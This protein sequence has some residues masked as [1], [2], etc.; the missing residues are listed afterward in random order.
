MLA[1][2]AMMTLSACDR[3]QEYIEGLN[4]APQITLHTGFES[5]VQIEDSIKVSSK[6]TLFWFS[7]GIKIEDINSNIKMV[8]M[9]TVQSGPLLLVQSDSI[10]VDLQL[11]DPDSKQDS[12][13]MKVAILAPGT[14]TV[15]F[16]II[17]SFSRRDSATLELQAFENLLPVVEYRVKPSPL[18]DHIRIIDLS[19]SYDR[20]SR[21]GGGIVLYNFH[22]DGKELTSTES[23]L[24]Y[25][26]PTRGTYIA[27]VFVTDNNLENS[28]EKSFSITIA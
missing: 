9:D 19:D 4:T 27:V 17:D 7:V 1:T 20:D 18:S 15:K 5:G 12:I 24:A 10:L 13:V 8:R 22:L 14:H 6:I 28:V 21:H 3:D 16:T 11:V 23:G 26:F 2:A 25:A